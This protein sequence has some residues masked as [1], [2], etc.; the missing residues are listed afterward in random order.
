MFNL[1]RSLRNHDKTTRCT[2]YFRNYNDICHFLHYFPNSA[3]PNKS[4]LKIIYFKILHHTL[5]HIHICIHILHQVHHILRSAHLCQLFRELDK[6]HLTIW[7]F[8][9]FWSWA[10]TLFVNNQR[11]KNTLEDFVPFV[12]SSYHLLHECMNEWMN[13]WMNEVPLSKGDLPIFPIM[14]SICL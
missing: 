10:I 8:M 2:K 11:K 7:G 14:V 9:V 3:F 6:T 12:P 1:F 13:E 4:I 5:K